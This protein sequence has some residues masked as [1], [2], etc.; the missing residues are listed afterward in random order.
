MALPTYRLRINW[1]DAADAAGLPLFTHPLADVTERWP[2]GR[3]GYGAGQFV[4]GQRPGTTW[5]FDPEQHQFTL[6]N[7]D[8]LLTPLGA[9]DRLTPIQL[10][11][12]H[13]FDL[14]EVGGVD[15]ILLW[16]GQCQRRVS[17]SNSRTADAVFNVFE[18]A[19]RGAR[20]A[21]SVPFEVSASGRPLDIFKAAAELATTARIG[22]DETRYFDPPAALWNDATIRWPPAGRFT[23]RAEWTMYRFFLN[24]FLQWGRPVFTTRRGQIGSVMLGD[25]RTDGAIDIDGVD[26]RIGFADQ[27]RNTIRN[28]AKVGGI[29]KLTAQL[30]VATLPDIPLNFNVDGSHTSDTEL[31]FTWTTVSG[32]VQ[33]IL[34]IDGGIEMTTRDTNFTF[35]G[36]TRDTAYLASVRAVNAQG[37]RGSAAYAEG[38]TA[39]QPTAPPPG[40]RPIPDAPMPRLIGDRPY[41]EGDRNLSDVLIAWLAPEHAAKYQVRAANGL[42]QSDRANYQTDETAATAYV[43]HA[44]AGGESFAIHVRAGNASGWGPWSAAL[45]VLTG[46]DAMPIVGVT[47]ISISETMK[48]GTGASVTARL[49]VTF[50]L[51]KGSAS[52]K[53]YLQGPVFT[54]TIERTVATSPYQIAGGDGVTLDLMHGTYTVEMAA[55]GADGRLSE[56]SDPVTHTITSSAISAPADVTA[57][58]RRSDEIL[59]RWNPDDTEAESFGVQIRAVGGTWPATWTPSLSNS[60]H[61]FGGLAAST[62]YE[63][64]VRSEKEGATPAE[65]DAVTATTLASTAL[66]PPVI[67]TA[68]AHDNFIVIGYTR[69]VNA[70]THSARIKLSTSS[71]WGAWADTTGLNSHSFTNLASD[72]SY[73]MQVRAELGIVTAES[74]IYTARTQSGTARAPG[75]VDITSTTAGSESTAFAWNAPTTGDAPTGYEYRITLASASATG[76]WTPN[77]LVRSAVVGQLRAGAR[78]RIEVRAFN[79]AGSGPADT[80]FTTPTARPRATPSAV[81]GLSVPNPAQPAAGSAFT[82]TATW[83]PA[84]GA[85]S[86]EAALRIG[87]TYEGWIA[88]PSSAL[89]IRS[90]SVSLRSSALF[91]LQPGTA[92]AL[93]VRGRNERGAGGSDSDAFTTPAARTVARPANVGGLRSRSIGTD[94]VQLAWNAAAN[95]QGY[96][97][98]LGTIGSWT[99]LGSRTSYRLTRGLRA[100]TSFTL[101][102]RAY[103]YNGSTR[104]TS[105]VPAQ[106]AFTTLAALTA[107]TLSAASAS[108]SSLRVT[109]GA[110]AGAEYYETR[111]AL[112]GTTAWSAPAQRSRSGII[113]G[114]REGAG[115]LVQARAVRG[116]ERG[117]WSASAGA[118]VARRAVSA[119]SV[120]ARGSGSRALRVSWTAVPSADAYFLR[121]RVQGTSVWSPSSWGRALRTNASSERLSGLVSG[122]TYEV[123]VRA[124]IGR[125]YTTWGR[126][127]ATAT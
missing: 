125:I 94:F 30:I 35:T 123:Q 67:T 26:I 32:A 40:P 90:S 37:Q 1:D 18:L 99:D 70:A 17:S 56:R 84:A 117:P 11:N 34:R 21:F 121:Y 105:P 112:A 104:Q 15:A 42:D 4:K 114:L 8:G 19:E 92:Y 64:R 81:T 122:S 98:R 2:G 23:D 57:T 115:Y 9:S 83:T 78:Y 5:S 62:A 79:S 93:R 51:P 77:G 60:S 75:R 43:F 126:T 25:S 14:Y 100:G 54:G 109:I 68:V 10:D 3:F 69:G 73:D 91:T 50:T 85:T 49:A 27:N 65:A 12:V 29:D 111:H 63:M 108:T 53:I 22:V 76:R 107:P 41:R 82:L 47:G 124:R 106:L 59:L 16:E 7:D 110:V 80:A 86:Y 120:S 31:R 127:T 44:L 39:A 72:Q 116:A 71:V 118:N 74:P 95:A 102:L 33:Y 52:A 46:T 20:A 28:S 58:P 13:A 61:T 88:I 66:G 96:E 24:W 119:P 101:F 103:N 87:S 6:V 45:N 48:Q 36:L 113:P 55:I 89:T 97:Y 38:T